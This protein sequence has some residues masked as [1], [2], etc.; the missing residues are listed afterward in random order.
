MIKGTRGV[1]DELGQIILNLQSDNSI[2][3]F[4][5]IRRLRGV[6]AA[7]KE[8]DTQLERIDKDLGE[9]PHD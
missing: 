6:L 2:G 4:L 8:I 3:E 9:L 7:V 5:L 1:I